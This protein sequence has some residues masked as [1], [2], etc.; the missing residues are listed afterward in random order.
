[1]LII[2]DAKALQIG[3]FV[4]MEPLLSPLILVCNFS[5]S[6]FLTGVK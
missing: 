1:M 6:I 4:V 2:S 5:I 3:L